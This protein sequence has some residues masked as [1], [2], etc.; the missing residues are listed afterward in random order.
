MGRSA[1]WARVARGTDI[2]SPR[3]EHPPAAPHVGCE[4]GGQPE[5]PQRLS[6]AHVLVPD[7]LNLPV[8]S[9]V[10][11][12]HRRN[13]TCDL[14]WPAPRVQRMFRGRAVRE[15]HPISSVAEDVESFVRDLERLS[16]RGLHDLVMPFTQ[17]ASFAVSKHRSR[18]ARHTR[19][20]CAEFTGFQ[21]ANDTSRLTHH[22]RELGIPCPRVYTDGPE[23][24]IEAIAGS[25]QYP[26][27]VKPRGGSEVGVRL[28]TSSEELIA[29][30]RTVEAVQPR[31]AAGSGYGG[32]GTASPAVPDRSAIEVPVL[33]GTAGL[34]RVGSNLRPQGATR[35]SYLLPHPPRL[36]RPGPTPGPPPSRNGCLRLRPS[37]L[38]QARSA[39]RREDPLPARAP[40][41]GAAGLT[42]PAHTGLRAARLHRAD[43]VRP[44]AG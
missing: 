31:S 27:I 11:S 5:R 44:G 43:A 14:A 6:M 40:S 4:H 39:S 34:R 7:T 33:Q 23:I 15:W 13:D 32:S 16:E 38:R 12:L 18:L 2:E 20:V 9:G 35:P 17:L 29:A 37:L 1:L 10:R 8:L 42:V 36:R 19:V 3:M 41:I 26:V 30:Y 25:A 21:L 28:A 22:A 24:D